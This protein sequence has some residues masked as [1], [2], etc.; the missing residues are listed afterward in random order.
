MRLAAIT[1]HLMELV[2]TTVILPPAWGTK[3]LFCPAGCI[4][5]GSGGST[6]SAGSNRC[7]GSNRST[8][9]K[10]IKFPG[11]GGAPFLPQKDT[12]LVWLDF[13][14][15]MPRIGAWGPRE[16]FILPLAGPG[17][18]SGWVRLGGAPPPTHYIC[19]IW[20]KFLFY[21]GLVRLYSLLLPIVRK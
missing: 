18:R 4:F 20:I 13:F 1:I 12:L 19:W 11:P 15:S 3:G 16:P 5:A 21:L 7:T 2:Q 10:S 14:R 9:P 17:R 6:G 8:T